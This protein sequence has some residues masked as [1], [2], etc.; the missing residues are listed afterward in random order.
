M[1][2]KRSARGKAI[3]KKLDVTDEKAFGKVVDEAVAEF[4]KLDIMV[5]N[6]GYNP[7]DTLINGG[8]YAKWKETLEVNVSVSPWAAG[9]PSA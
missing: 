6:A 5:N 9:K 4:G 7:F 2:A 1:E 3:V 8:D